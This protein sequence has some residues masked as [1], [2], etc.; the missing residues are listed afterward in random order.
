[1]IRFRSILHAAS[2]VLTFALAAGITNAS[3]APKVKIDTGT[4]AGKSEGAIDAFLGI[5]YAA[6]PV[7]DLRWKPP[8]PALLASAIARANS[9]LYSR[10]A[11]QSR[12]NGIP[13]CGRFGGS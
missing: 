1:M 7:G 9:A 10:Y 8:A 6:P 11:A 3:P 12:R 13:N 5:P 2:L 4:V